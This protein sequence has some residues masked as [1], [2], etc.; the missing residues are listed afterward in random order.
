[1]FPVTVRV[2]TADVT[3]GTNTTA[4][5]LAIVSKSRACLAQSSTS[6]YPVSA[7]T[8]FNIGYHY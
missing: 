6:K 3:S 4:K 1:M 5:W 7:E 8:C 2:I